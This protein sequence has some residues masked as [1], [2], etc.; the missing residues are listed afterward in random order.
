MMKQAGLLLLLLG[1]FGTPVFGGLK[2]D[3]NVIERAVAADAE[4]LTVDFPF[5]VTGDQAVEIKSFD[6][7]CSCLTAE[8]S[9]GGQLKWK[10]GEKGVV[11]GHFELG[12]FKGTIEKDIILKLSG[13]KD[14][15]R[16]K[17]VVTIPELLK[18]EP[19]IQRWE[20]GGSVE[21][22]SFKITLHD[23]QPIKILNLIMTN[24]QFKHEMI[25]VEEGREYQL[26]VTPKD[27]GTRTVGRVKIQTDSK[28]ARHQL[29]QAFVMVQKPKTP[30]KK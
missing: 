29:Y 5:E 2:F 13:Q 6:A 18:I 12:T 9:G 21:P 30:P 19:S 15:V 7:P 16:L 22:K 27:V 24:P 3:N 17:S 23:E 28:F 11:R 1:F 26:V 4:K 20:T 14:V 8:I 25:T 10:P